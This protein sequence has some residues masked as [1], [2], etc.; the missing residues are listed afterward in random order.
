MWQWVWEHI[1]LPA[2]GTS[3]DWVPWPV[4]LVLAGLLLGWAWKTF[5]WQGL[6][7]AA[8]AVLTVGAYQKGWR[9]NQARL[10]GKDT[11]PRT[12]TILDVFRPKALPP[13]TEERFNPKRKRTYN[14]DTNRWE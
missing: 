8:L 12:D 5:G 9:D 4:W 6:V 11:L 10:R 14:P 3:I 1:A 7:G 13:K 2:I